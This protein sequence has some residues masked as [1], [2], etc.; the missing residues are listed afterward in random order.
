M[1]LFV[2]LELPRSL[3]ER[4]GLLAGGIPGARWVPVGQLP[5]DLALHR[6]SA[7]PTVPRRSTTRWPRSARG[8]FP[9]QPFRR[10]HLRA[11]RAR[12][13]ALGGRRAHASAGALAVKI[14]TALQP[15]RRGPGTTPVLA[16]RDARPPVRHRG[17]RQARRLRPGTQSVPRRAV[18]GRPLHAVQLPAG[19][20]GVGLHG[21]SRIPAATAESRCGGLRTRPV[22]LQHL[23]RRSL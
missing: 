14:E 7:R 1:R 17:R 12:R 6:R 16:A 20:R 15:R 5:H 11:R 23:V 4:L 22:A 10:R 19:Q 18:R 2:G 8:A 9:L 21:R 13:G 3:R